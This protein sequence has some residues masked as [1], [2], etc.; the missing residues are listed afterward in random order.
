MCKIV[1]VYFSDS[2]RVSVLFN[3]SPV[4]TEEVRIK[5]NRTAR[6]ECIADSNPRPSVFRWSYGDKKIENGTEGR[7]LNLNSVTNRTSG[8]HKCTV[9]VTSRGGYT[10][11][12]GI[13]SVRIKVQCKI[14]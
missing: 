14:I 9:S 3:N 10:I 5:E 11:P 2:P 8:M 13:A 4:T 7:L 6:L 1:S 12:N